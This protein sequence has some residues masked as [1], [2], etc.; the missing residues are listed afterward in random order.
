MADVQAMTQAV[1]QA[2]IEA[3]RTAVWAITGARAEVGARPSSETASMEPKLG[4]P[5]WK[6]VTFDKS[7]TCKYIELKNFKLE[8]ND[9]SDTQYK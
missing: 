6:E 5:T 3:V 1:T 2:A 7:M 4:R 8:V 9:I